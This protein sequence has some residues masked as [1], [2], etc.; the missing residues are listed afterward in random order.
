MLN[1]N[2]LLFFNIKN[3]FFFTVN[4]FG[5]EKKAVLTFSWLKVAFI[6]QSLSE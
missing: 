4:S 6:S 2:F 1:Y 3:N 5:P